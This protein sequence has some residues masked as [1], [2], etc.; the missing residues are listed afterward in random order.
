MHSRSRAIHPSR[1]SESNH[2][3]EPT[4]MGALVPSS[5]ARLAVAH[6]G[7]STM[8]GN[9]HRATFAVLV[10]VIT[11]GHPD[12]PGSEIKTNSRRQGTSGRHQITDYRRDAWGD[13][14]AET[15]HS[16][17]PAR[18]AFSGEQIVQDRSMT[19]WSNHRVEP[20][21]TAAPLGGAIKATGSVA[22]AVAV[23]H[24]GRSTMQ[25]NAHRATFGDPVHVITSEHPGSPDSDTKTNS[26]R[27]G[28]PEDI[29]FQ[30]AGETPGV[31]LELGQDI[32]TIRHGRHSPEGGPC[33]IGA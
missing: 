9:A 32:N 19:C 20:T 2:R 29:R 27:Q 21:A 8:Q 6:P 1:A 31:T 26:R 24:P 30:I 3:V 25:G 22:Q 10:H 15:R 33:R 17:T 28:H 14:R 4:A 16:F 23:A 18:E 7:R 5:A 13:S 12:S 11:S